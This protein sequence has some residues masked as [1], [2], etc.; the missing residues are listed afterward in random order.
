M[1]EVRILNR[2]VRWTEA[3]LLYEADERHE[4]IVVREMGLEGAKAAPTPGTREEQ[5][6]ARMPT[7]ALKVEVVD[8]SPELSAKDAKNH[9]GVAAGCN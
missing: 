8:E 3:G 9:R 1:L 2:V 7:A 4:E 5:K 6:S